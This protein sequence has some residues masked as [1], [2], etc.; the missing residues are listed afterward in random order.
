MSGIAV[1]DTIDAIEQIGCGPDSISI[2]RN[3]QEHLIP[4]LCR[5][6]EPVLQGA[7]DTDLEAE[8]GGAIT[9]TW[10]IPIR[11][12]DLD[13]A[14]QRLTL[15]DI[16]GTRL[17]WRLRFRNRAPHPGLGLRHA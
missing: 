9:P 11:R 6:G 3:G 7:F 1:F 15:E 4:F 17:V 13:R 5:R 12:I 14:G 16:R 2:I 10:P 8:P